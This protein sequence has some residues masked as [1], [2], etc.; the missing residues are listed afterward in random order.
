MPRLNAA[1]A[2]S[3][4]EASRARAYSR[5]AS[6]SAPCS[7]SSRPRLTSA[8]AWSDWSVRT[9]SYARRAWALAQEPP[10]ARALGS[11]AYLAGVA[12]LLIYVGIV[13]AESLWELFDMQLFNAMFIGLLA[14]LGVSVIQ[15]LL[16]GRSGSAFTAQIGSMKAREELDAIRTLGLSPAT[17]D[18]AARVQRCSHVSTR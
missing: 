1:V 10:V 8:S 11:L 17:T 3:P 12:A 13:L 14:G 6:S 7:W 4:P 5:A 15:E 16:P 18:L 2:R 9:F